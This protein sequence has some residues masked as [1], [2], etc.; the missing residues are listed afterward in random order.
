[1]RISPHFSA[2]AD[3]TTVICGMEFEKPSRPKSHSRSNPVF[4][5]DTRAGDLSTKGQTKKERPAVASRPLS[6]KLGR[7]VEALTDSR[8]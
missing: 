7:D 4:D 8:S 2:G 3:L 6:P 1:M 5:E